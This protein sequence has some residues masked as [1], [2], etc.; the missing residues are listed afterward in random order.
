[1]AAAGFKIR[2]FLTGMSVIVSDRWLPILSVSIVSI[3]VLDVWLVASTAAE[4]DDWCVRFVGC[5][6]RWLV[7]IF[8]RR[9]GCKVGDFVV[10][11]IASTDLVTTQV[12]T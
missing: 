1:M 3:V 11:I 5:G 6:I 4:S 12:P 2:I 7:G 10:R 8:V 9:T